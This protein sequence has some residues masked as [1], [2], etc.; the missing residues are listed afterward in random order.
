[1]NPLPEASCAPIHV[2]ATPDGEVGA[3]AGTCHQAWIRRTSPFST[4][5]PNPYGGKTCGGAR[6]SAGSA[7]GEELETRKVEARRA[8]AAQRE[9]NLKGQFFR[10]ASFP[11]MDPVTSSVFVPVAPREF[12]GH[13]SHLSVL[14]GGYRTYLFT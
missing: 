6:V 12:P 7:D 9:S 4:Y 14:C 11:T 2:A 8:K 3:I 13:H 10:D 1:M 5:P